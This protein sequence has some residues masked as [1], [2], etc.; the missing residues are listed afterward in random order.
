MKIQL[1]YDCETRF[2]S[3]QSN[4]YHLLHVCIHSSCV[5]QTLNDFLSLKQLLINILV[6]IS[7]TMHSCEDAS[8][9]ESYLSHVDSCVDITF[10]RS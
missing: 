2:N 1:T 8:P 10:G 6:L 3:I 9:A 7:S 4:K 5:R